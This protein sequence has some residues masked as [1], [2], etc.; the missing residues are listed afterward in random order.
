MK[1]L[2]RRP[3]VPSYMF[4]FI[5]TLG[6]RPLAADLAAAF[7]SLVFLRLRAQVDA[8][9]AGRQPDNMI[10]LDQLNRMEQKQLRTAVEVV[11]SLQGT[12]QRRFRPGAII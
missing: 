11:R 2:K 1:A 8:I 10:S 12:L 7:D 6:D 3:L 9:S 5:C 4:M